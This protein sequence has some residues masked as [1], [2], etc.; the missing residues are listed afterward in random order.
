MSNQPHA[1]TPPEQVRAACAAALEAAEDYAAL[2][3]DVR[4]ALLEDAASA[5]DAA[6]VEIVALADEETKLG[7]DRLTG[8]LARTTGQL[9]LFASA[10]REGSFLD[11]IIDPPT[12]TRPD[13]RRML[14][15]LG[16][17]AVFSASNFPLAF[18]V[19]GGDTASA[20]A[21]GCPVVV[22]AHSGHP[23]LSALVHS[24]LAPILPPGVISIVY[25]REAGRLLVTDEAIT[26]V[27]FTGSPAGGRTLW[28]LANARPRPIPFYGELGSINPVVVTPDAAAQRGGDI[29]EG[30]VGSFTLGQGQFC[31][32]PGLLFLP[33]GHGLT[34]LLAQAVSA[35]T[36]GPLLGTWIADGFQAAL[37]ALRKRPGVRELAVG[38]AGA[39]PAPVL[40]AV[41]AREFG[42]EMAVECFGPASVVVEYASPEELFAALGHVPGTLTLTV[43]T[44]PGGD[45]GLAARLL[46]WGEQHAG[47]LVVNGWPTG[48]AVAWST[49]HGGPWPATTAP[50]FTSV[51]VTAI[52]RFLRPVAYQNV[53][54]ALL[55][56]AL[57]DGNP[58]G[59][60]RRVTAA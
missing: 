25:G 6:A 58:L 45:D 10:V 1:A 46:R 19:A 38:S 11:I 55:P 56:L 15:P 30:F 27:G 3:L 18:S 59:L 20:L 4:A 2:P 37:A 26:A 49:H 17:V 7:P 39:G 41:P 57:R 31:T 8:E 40:L 60:P 22:K 21:A 54:D 52:R 23:R 35:R 28:E 24:L 12:S 48:L 9:R 53:P 50:L 42:P 36:G 14:V 32:K 51:G 33:A 13:L 5:L 47:R 29:V 34:G 44:E 16:P 43:H